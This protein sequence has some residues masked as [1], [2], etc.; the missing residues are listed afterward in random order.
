MYIHPLKV[1][2]LS[3]KLINIWNLG[4]AYVKDIFLDPEQTL[5][6]ANHEGFFKR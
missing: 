2:A 3:L 6:C 1:L 5:S 4:I